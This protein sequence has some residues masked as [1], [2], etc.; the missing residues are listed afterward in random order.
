MRPGNFY[1][2]FERAVVINDWPIN[3]QLARCVP[4]FELPFR[5]IRRRPI[6]RID[7]EERVVVESEVSACEGPA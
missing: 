1:E 6:S 3:Y 2:L 7:V 4:Q 5:L